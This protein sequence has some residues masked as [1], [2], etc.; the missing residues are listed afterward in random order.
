VLFPVSD[1]CCC[2]NGME[3]GLPGSKAVT[4]TSRYR[5]ASTDKNQ[6]QK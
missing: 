2:V 1:D 3:D 4:V 6:K 5:V